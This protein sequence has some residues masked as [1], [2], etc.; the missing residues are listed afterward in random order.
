MIC[1]V[2]P[3]LSNVGLQPTLRTAEVPDGSPATVTVELVGVLIGSTVTAW[4]ENADGVGAAT[5]TAQVALVT[6]M[7]STMDVN[8][9]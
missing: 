2:A 5:E 4:K 6:P 3:L 7:L 1:A 8:Q 9:P